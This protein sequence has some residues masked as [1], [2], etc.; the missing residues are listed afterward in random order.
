MKEIQL[1]HLKLLQ[2]GQ[3]LSGYPPGTEVLAGDL[4]VFPPPHYLRHLRHFS[5]LWAPSSLSVCRPPQ[6]QQL[7]KGYLLHTSGALVF[8]AAV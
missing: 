5:G 1:L 3:G 2:E 4:F 8:A 7:P 6:R